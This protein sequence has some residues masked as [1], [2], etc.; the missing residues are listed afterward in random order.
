MTVGV[1]KAMQC[2]FLTGIPIGQVR[3]QAGELL[4]LADL[5]PVMGHVIKYASAANEV[6]GTAVCEPKGEF[7]A[8]SL[9]F[10]YRS[11]MGSDVTWHSLY[12]SHCGA[13]AL[14]NTVTVHY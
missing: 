11:R 1:M 10:I 5:C 14:C 4:K 6:T 8:C 7:F 2:P 3:Q 13:G 9:V 12:N